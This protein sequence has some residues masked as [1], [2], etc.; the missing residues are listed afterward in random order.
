MTSEPQAISGGEALDKA[1]D[2]AREHPDQADSVLDKIEDALSKQTGGRFDDLIGKGRDAVDAAL[3]LPGDTP[4]QP[5]AQ[6]ADPAPPS[7]PTQPTE[8]SEPAQPTPTDPGQ[9]APPADPGST[10]TDPVLVPEPDPQ[11]SSPDAPTPGA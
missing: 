2:Y 1:K 10:P 6:P 8:P 7:D 4:A 9:S 11:P 3:G 5:P